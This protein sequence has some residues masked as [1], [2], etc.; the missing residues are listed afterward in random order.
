[1]GASALQYFDHV[2]VDEA[3]DVLPLEW[4]LL[5]RLNAGDQWSLFGDMQQRRSDWCYASWAELREAVGLPG[6]AEVQQC[7]G[8]YRST[9]AIHAFAARLLPPGERTTGAVQAGG[10]LPVVVQAHP[11]ALAREALARAVRLA[12]D[13]AHGTIAVVAPETANLRRLLARTGWSASA[14]G[15][16]TW[17]RGRQELRVLTPHD[18]RGLEFDGVVVVEPAHFPRNLGR[19]GLLYTSLTRANRSLVVVH[20]AAL[21]DELRKAVRSG[22][23]IPARGE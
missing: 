23:A 8:V 4:R 9:A 12:D 10:A 21:P 14:L 6:D 17:T 5:A 22:L 3:Q 1:M 20:A 2:V 7:G 19:R 16:D 15:A 18:A 13:H 11:D